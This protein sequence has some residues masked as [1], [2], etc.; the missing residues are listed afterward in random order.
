MFISLVVL[1]AAAKKKKKTENALKDV[2]LVA[3][4]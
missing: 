4:T 1:L 2:A 3:G